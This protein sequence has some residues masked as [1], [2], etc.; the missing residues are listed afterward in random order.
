MTFHTLGTGTTPAPFG[1]VAEQF[2]PLR[3]KPITFPVSRVP[4]R[5][6][7]PSIK[8]R[9]GSTR[10]KFVQNGRLFSQ[11]RFKAHN[12]GG[13]GHDLSIGDIVVGIPYEIVGARSVSSSDAEKARRNTPTRDTSPPGARLLFR[14]RKSLSG[15]ENRNR[16]G[17]ARRQ[18][19]ASHQNF[20][21]RGGM[22]GTAPVPTRS[23]ICRV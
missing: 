5:L 13:L 21:P 23:T 10:S 7:L 22:S 12:I 20:A 2:E 6:I 15:S 17:L 3:L 1:E 19:K 18:L 16:C 4:R 8:E 14:H 11:L 9:G